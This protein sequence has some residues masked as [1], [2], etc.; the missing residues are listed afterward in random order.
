MAQIQFV[1]GVDVDRTLRAALVIVV[2]L[3]LLW[4]V[5]LLVRRPRDAARAESV[6]T[7][8]AEDVHRQW[9]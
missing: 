1:R 8:G 6:I 3:V 2:A 5:V 9:E 7:L 4:G